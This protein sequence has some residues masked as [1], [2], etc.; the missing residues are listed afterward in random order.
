MKLSIRLKKDENGSAL[1]F[2]LLIMMVVMFLTS[3]VMISSV[4]A[5]KNSIAITNNTNYDGVID[6]AISDMYRVMENR[7][8]PVNL[9]AYIG[10]PNARKGASADGKYKWAWY[11]TPIVNTFAKTTYKATV[12]GAKSLT[13]IDPINSKT[14]YLTMNS[15]AVSGGVV[16]D[17]IP[18]YFPT[19]DGVYDKAIFGRNNVNVNGTLTLNSIAL[20]GT[21][22]NKAEI[23]TSG[24]VFV[25]NASKVPAMT[26]FASPDIDGNTSLNRCTGSACNLGYIENVPLGRANNDVRTLVDNECSTTVPTNVTTSSLTLDPSKSYCYKNL[27]LQGN[28][29]VTNPTDT[30]ISSGNPVRIYVTEN[31]TIKPGTSFNSSSTIRDASSLKF[32]FYVRQNVDVASTGT[33]SGTTNF[34]GLIASE[35]SCNI[36]QPAAVVNFEGSLSCNDKVNTNGTVNFKWDEQAK[37]ITP[38]R[39]AQQRVWYP[40]SISNN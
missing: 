8:T 30:S 14:I 36:G 11:L 19:L 32:R 37:Q 18:H 16:L 39:Y 6:T 22:Q 35:A 9:E 12:V 2:S 34:K 31:L 13:P 38:D 24:S 17:G 5:S 27:T 40:V 25:S 15:T 10:L 23:A 33:L 4:N 29:T 20:N 28:V 7:S 26:F 21:L 1:V 3:I